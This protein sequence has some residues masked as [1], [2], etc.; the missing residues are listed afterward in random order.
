[1]NNLAA[2]ISSHLVLFA[3]PSVLLLV[4]GHWLLA[5]ASN[6]HIHIHTHR[7]I[8]YIGTFIYIDIHIYSVLICIIYFK[9][10]ASHSHSRNTRN[11]GVKG[12]RRKIATDHYNDKAM[13]AMSWIFMK[14]YLYEFIIIL[15]SS[16]LLLNM[17]QKCNLREMYDKCSNH[18]FPSVTTIKRNR[19]HMNT[20]L[21]LKRLERTL[22][23]VRTPLSDHEPAAL[24][25]TH[26]Q[27]T[28]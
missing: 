3:W 10:C 5:L 20:T 16:W 25:N 23:P 28:E 7:H 11:P 17:Q 12:L 4:Y 1:M 22:S 2:Y 21:K 26:Q 14:V 27:R 9:W 18:N 24:A 19:R 8:Q 6:V 13:T 15:W